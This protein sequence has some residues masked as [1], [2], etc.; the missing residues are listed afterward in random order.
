M[1][2]VTLTDSF[3]AE[4][5]LAP[6]QDKQSFTDPRV[7]NLMLL[8]S[9][10]GSVYRNSPTSDH[11]KKVWYFR[12]NL[13][14]RNQLKIGDWPTMSVGE[15]ISEAKRL[16][17]LVSSGL[18]PR[19]D[20]SRRKTEEYIHAAQL[21]SE[22]PARLRFEVVMS[23]M[24]AYW[25]KTGKSQSTLDNYIKALKKHALPLFAGRNI[26]SI[27]GKEWEDIV[28]DLANVQGKKGAANNLHK[29]GR[30]LFTFALDQELINSNPLLRRKRT[31]EATRLEPDARFLDADEVSKFMNEI[32][33][34]AGIA[35]WARIKLKIMML[36]GVRIEEWDRVRIGWINFKNMRIEHPSESMKN[37]RKAWTHLPQPAVELLLDWLKYLKRSNNNKLDPNWYLFPD[38]KDPAQPQKK[39][40]SEEV[41]ELSSWIA[42]TPKMIRKTISTHL[43][44]QGCPPVVLKAIRN[45]TIATGVES[46]YNFDDLFHL[47][48]QW[49]EKWSELLEEAKKNPSVLK[50]DRDSVL[51]QSL[52]A[53]VDDL[54]S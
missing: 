24:E 6:S 32:D 16:N 50:T 7:K 3:I 35:L 22:V 30:R 52:S 34:Q 12:F 10:R 48:K 53:E 49:I 33:L 2:R 36:V 40:L 11:F 45:H 51:D 38:E 41:R 26:R 14:G 17:G 19:A 43:Q 23:E 28:L 13:N 29:A 44:R 42:F 31:I 8:V 15:A 27:S 25:P 1:S 54:F 5:M 39:E 46:S 4:L 21:T 47:K 9:W 18:D 37:R 20:Y